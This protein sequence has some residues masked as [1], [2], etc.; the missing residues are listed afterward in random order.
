MR[1]GRRIDFDVGPVRLAA[2]AYGDPGH[3]PVVLLHGGGQTRHA[4]GRTAA[5]LGAQGRYAIAVDLRGHGDSDWAPDADYSE[6]TFTL[7]KD[8]ALVMV[9]DGVV[10]G[11]A[12]T[13]DAGLERAGTLAAQA[14]H[15][16][17]RDGD[18]GPDHS[19]RCTPNGRGE[20]DVALAR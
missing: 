12:L 20:V 15:D 14:V 8:A 16:V 1:R 3:A 13:L 10:E 18:G 6:E 11:P 19:R 17:T 4:W 7:D 2:D 9:T 5:A